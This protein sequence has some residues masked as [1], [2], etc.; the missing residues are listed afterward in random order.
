MV[1]VNGFRRA[2]AMLSYD[3]HSLRPFSMSRRWGLSR[4]WLS[5][6]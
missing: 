4:D 2:L 5:S 3:Y 6:F 1:L